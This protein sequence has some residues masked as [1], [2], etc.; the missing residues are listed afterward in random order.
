MGRASSDRKVKK[1]GCSCERR[2]RGVNDWS[3]PCGVSVGVAGWRGIFVG[4]ISGRNWPLCQHQN[5]NFLPSF[6]DNTSQLKVQKTY[7]GLARSVNTDFLV[8]AEF[9][10]IGHFFLLPLGLRSIARDFCFEFST[11]IMECWGAVPE[12]IRQQLVVV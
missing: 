2:I 4:E 10:K 8:S 1:V 3:R 5:L 7:I 12:R 9:V 6:R 11:L